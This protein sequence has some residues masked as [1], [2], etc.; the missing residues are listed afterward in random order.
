MTD[1]LTIPG[2]HISYLGMSQAVLP[3][4]N[5]KLHGTPKAGTSLPHGLLVTLL[6]VPHIEPPK[7]SRAFHLVNVRYISH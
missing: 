2:I 7:T 6:T 3:Q 1:E 4:A 5:T